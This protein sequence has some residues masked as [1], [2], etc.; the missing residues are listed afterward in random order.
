M[1]EIHVA[2]EDGTVKL[3][4][5]QIYD[6]KYVKLLGYLRISRVE[7]VPNQGAGDL[8]EVRAATNAEANGP[9][10]RSLRWHCRQV[11]AP[12][13]GE[14]FQLLIAAPTHSAG[15]VATVPGTPATEPGE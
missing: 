6:P 15:V 1:A 8:V 13:A 2:T 12:K 9:L 7:V 4:P 11:D 3:S 5:T 10:W 14:V